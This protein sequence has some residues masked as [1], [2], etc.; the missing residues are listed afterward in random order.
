VRRLSAYEEVAGSREVPK[1]PNWPAMSRVSERTVLLERPCWELAGSRN[2]A[3]P[4]CGSLELRWGR[5]Q[6]DLRN[7]DGVRGD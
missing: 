7:S 1:A 6:P 4:R 5:E 3:F 2:R